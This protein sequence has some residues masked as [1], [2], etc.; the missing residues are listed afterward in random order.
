MSKR[1]F[2]GTYAAFSSPRMQSARQHH[3]VPEVTRVR[4]LYAAIKIPRASTGWCLADRNSVDHSPHV[5]RKSWILPHTFLG[6]RGYLKFGLH[7]T[8][9]ELRPAANRDHQDYHPSTG[10]ILVFLT[11][12]LIPH[13]E[14][15]SKRVV[16]CR[17]R[18]LVRRGA[19]PANPSSHIPTTHHGA[20][21]RA[22]S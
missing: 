20:Y 6:F 4:C 7:G 8:F 9:E 5:T 22:S 16:N 18:S 14:T 10:R 15:P 1:P 13:I 12:P 3:E 21:F 2:L 17:R 19:K 11:P